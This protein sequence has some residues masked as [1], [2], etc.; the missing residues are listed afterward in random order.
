M[1]KYIYLTYKSHL[2]LNIMTFNKIKIIHNLKFIFCFRF[3][4]DL[5]ECQIHLFYRSNLQCAHD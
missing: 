3:E 1:K 4:Q 2:T 5:L